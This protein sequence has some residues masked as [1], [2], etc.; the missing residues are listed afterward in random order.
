[1][2]TTMELRASNRERGKEVPWV[3]KGS[4]SLLGQQEHNSIAWDKFCRHFCIEN[5]PA[6]QTNILLKCDF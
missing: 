4:Q 2:C 6:F 5:I 1:M 3:L